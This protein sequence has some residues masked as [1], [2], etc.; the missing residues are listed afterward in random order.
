M[1][2]DQNEFGKKLRTLRR[3]RGITQEELAEMLNIEK[4]HVSRMENG[5]RSCSIDLLIEIACQLHTS[6]DYLLMGREPHRNQEREQLLTVIGQLTNLV[7]R[8]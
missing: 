6:T 8:M 7:K 3:A 1:Y 5:M 2:F 4:L